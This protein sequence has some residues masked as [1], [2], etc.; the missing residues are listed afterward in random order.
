MVQPKLKLD[1]GKSRCTLPISHA[2]ALRI[3]EL[4]AESA[5]DGRR[6]ALSRMLAED[7]FF[8]V[9]SVCKMDQLHQTP[10]HC[11]DNVA[12][13]L[14]GDLFSL[15]DWDDQEDTEQASDLME[16]HEGDLV[17]ASV[18][19]ALLAGQFEA[20]DENGAQATTKSNATRGIYESHAYFFA[21]LHN[22]PRIL[23]S[24][25]DRVSS[26]HSLPAWLEQ[27][28]ATLESHSNL[29]GTTDAFVRDAIQIV[30]NSF[31]IDQ[32]NEPQVRAQLDRAAKIRDQWTAGTQSPHSDGSTISNRL[33]AQLQARF[34]R[35]DQLENRFEDV[36]EK[37]KLEAL[38]ELAYGASHEINNPL[39]NISTRAQTLL[40]EETDPER[41]KKIATIN[42]QALRAHEM[43][44]EMMLFAK[45]PRL[46]A[47]LTNVDELIQRVAA[48]LAPVAAQQGS[49]ISVNESSPPDCERMILCDSDHMVEAIRAMC[50]NSLE[51]LVSGGW[52]ELSVTADLQ[53]NNDG[54]KWVRIQVAD[55]G[56]GIPSEIISHIF[57]PFFS[58]REAGR[59]LGF[60]LSKCWRIVTEH[61]GHIDLES[62]PRRGT[63]FTIHLPGTLDSSLPEKSGSLSKV[64]AH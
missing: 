35:L 64:N 32:S 47:R 60:G 5:S 16:S 6:V 29:N 27:K 44:A 50:Q 41:R 40:R 20:T 34:A 30:T 57:E 45:P 12:A 10:P 58:G 37:A 39:A 4:F 14:E 8:A 51:A 63:V 59:G 18:A 21:L 17:F 26:E 42:S 33:M 31:E 56:P 61:G 24:S 54:T 52:I 53:P 19:T 46:D 38:R 28:N 13:W 62:Q 49:E 25:N 2:S 1:I 22:A 3:V 7:P 15:L 55:N 48:E 9:W 23:E 11:V 43:I 36:V